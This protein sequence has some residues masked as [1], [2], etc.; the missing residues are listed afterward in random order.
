MVKK[1]VRGESRRRRTLS[2]GG[3]CAI[4]LFWRERHY[5]E[6]IYFTAHER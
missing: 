1:I 5:E 2:G 3:R 6:I 4:F